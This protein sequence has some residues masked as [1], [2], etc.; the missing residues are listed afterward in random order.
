M[1]LLVAFALGVFAYW[2][3]DHAIMFVLRRYA[4]DAERS[5]VIRKRLYAGAD[6]DSLL[7]I[8]AALD[9]EIARRRL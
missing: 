1:K 5:D 3:V 4:S 2:L 7:R 8:R 6:Y 9:A